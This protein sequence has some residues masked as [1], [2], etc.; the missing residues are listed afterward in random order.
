MKPVWA[1]GLMT[2]T[3]L[4]GMIDVALV[5]TD[6]ETIAELGPWSLEPYGDEAMTLIPQAVAA[7]RAWQFDGPEPA[8]FAKA[9]AA[10]TRAQS[11]AVLNV[12]AKA[13]LRAADISIIGFHGQTMLHRAPQPGK[14]GQTL[15]LGDGTMMAQLTGID[16]A[17]DFR[18]HDMSLGGQG[19]PLVPV[20]HVALL[21]HAGLTAPVAALNLGGVGNVTW[22][23]GGD[24][25]VA[26]D[27]GPANGPLNDWV[28]QHGAGDFDRDSMIASRGT[29][30]EARLAKLLE[31]PYFSRKP[32]KSLDRFDF[33]AS[34]AEGLSLEDG[35][36]TLT[37]FSAAAVGKALDL[38]PQRPGK[39]ILCGGGRKNPVLV[40]EI[41]K[42]AQ[43]QPVDCETVGW[44]GDAV[45]A[46]CFAYLAVR[47]M[48]GLPLSFPLTTG[49]PTPSTGGRIARANQRVA[50]SR[51]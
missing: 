41:A 7:A 13:G 49:V 15:Q 17:H 21:K 35:A 39:I 22:W 9:E 44:R 23:G 51:L 45:E 2:G 19:A 1:V 11:A 40:R 30:D 24:H 20:W 50:A 43:A 16:V 14:L 38:L 27:T 10:L 28:A 48:R 47:T 4:D 6:G 33:Q 37:A 29:V 12:I 3:A 25:V 8:I 31:H 36:A 26:F 32:A 34:M 46:E 42:R 18:S 5:R